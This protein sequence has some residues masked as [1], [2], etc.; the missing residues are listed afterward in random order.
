MWTPRSLAWLQLLRVVALVSAKIRITELL[1]YPKTDDD[2]EFMEIW[3]DSEEPVDLTGERFSGG[4]KFE[5]VNVSM[6]PGAV[7]LLVSDQSA[8]E[9]RFG[10]DLNIAGE[11]KKKLSNS[12]DEITGLGYDFEYGVDEGWPWAKAGYSINPIYV[13][14]NYGYGPNWILAEPSPGVIHCDHT[15]VIISE[16]ALQPPVP[17]VNQNNETSGDWRFVELLNP[18]AGTVVTPVQIR[19]ANGSVAV[20]FNRIGPHQVAL[21][22]CNKEDF[23]ALY[24]GVYAAQVVSSWRIKPMDCNLLPMSGSNGDG[25]GDGEDDGEGARVVLTTTG[26]DLIDSMLGD[27]PTAAAGH[28]VVRST[29]S[30]ALFWAS[31][32]DLGGSPGFWTAADYKCTLDGIVPALFEPSGVAVDPV[33]GRALVASDDGRMMEVDLWTHRMVRMHHLEQGLD[34][35]GVTVAEP[36]SGLVY[37]GV[38][39]EHLMQRARILEFSLKTSKVTR[40]FILDDL[41]VAFVDGISKGLE[42]LTFVPSNYSAEGGQFYAGSQATGRVYVY[43]L[44]IKTDPFDLMTYAVPTTSFKPTSSENLAGAT[45]YDDRLFM[46]FPSLQKVY[47]YQRAGMSTIEV[48][49]EEYAM[50]EVR[51]GEGIAMWAEGTGKAASVLVASDEHHSIVKLRFSEAEA[52]FSQASCLSFHRTGQLVVDASSAPL[53]P[54]Q[55]SSE[56]ASDSSESS[57]SAPGGPLVYS[58]QESVSTQCR[59]H[60]LTLLALLLTSTTVAT[61]WS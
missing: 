45:Y 9:K 31:S 12:G 46:S 27:L 14:G 25:D 40:R 55:P 61:L 13:R 44:T 57:S 15:K 52:G 8:F 36:G 49:K 43:D 16:V 56:T 51:D 39:Y 37:L 38:E 28:T 11:Y 26:G 35:E 22:V 18:Q 6:L 29:L 2:S 54:S 4:I 5:F 34:L 58:A 21:A 42:A 53:P 41:P 7:A 23:L 3:N 32:H 24:S 60:V 59:A 48:F 17:L 30:T 47:V 10:A 1:Y 19:T 50:A 33:L 20:T